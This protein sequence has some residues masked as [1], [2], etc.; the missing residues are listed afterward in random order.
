[1]IS[2]IKENRSSQWY[3]RC[4]VGRRLRARTRARLLRAV[5]AGPPGR[6]LRRVLSSLAGSLPKRPCSSPFPGEGLAEPQSF[7]PLVGQPQDRV[8][9]HAV[10]RDQDAEEHRAGGR[11]RGHG[12]QRSRR[13]TASLFDRALYI[14]DAKSA[15]RCRRAQDRAEQAQA[16][17]DEG[18]TLGERGRH[19]QPPEEP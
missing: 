17:Q 14:E 6:F 15:D 1:M 8:P 4:L 10:A 7:G 16:E 5:R 11:E 19:R 2:E 12:G 3:E 18:P 9:E 13:A